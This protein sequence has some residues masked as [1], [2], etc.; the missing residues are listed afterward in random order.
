M[1]IFG[2]WVSDFATKCGQA[3][4]QQ[5][6]K[7]L[8]GAVFAVELGQP[9]AQGGQLGD[10]GLDFFRAA[11]AGGVVMDFGGEAADERVGL[12]LI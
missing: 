12:G 6:V 1:G 7:P 9:F 11:L 5:P 10:K 8:V 2:R 3:V 4:I